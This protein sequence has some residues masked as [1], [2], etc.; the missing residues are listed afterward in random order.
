MELRQVG[1]GVG[2]RPQHAGDDRE[3]QAATD[4]WGA[5]EQRDAD[6]V[7]SDRGGIRHADRRAARTAAVPP[8]FRAAA[9]RVAT[10]QQVAGYTWLTVSRI[11]K[12]RERT[13]YDPRIAAALAENAALLKTIGGRLQHIKSTLNEVIWLPTSIIA[14]GPSGA[15]TD[16]VS[17]RSVAAD[18]A[19]SGWAVKG[20]ACGGTLIATRSAL[21]SSAHA[22]GDAVER[23]AGG[24]GT[25]ASKSCRR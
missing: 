1:G 10:G 25:W 21:D 18:C 6:D 7:V 3:W 14:G 17:L 12:A 23:S 20:A 16:S 13:G 19:S 2:R 9:A 15:S 11:A 5:R 8:P 24:I 4:S 22:D